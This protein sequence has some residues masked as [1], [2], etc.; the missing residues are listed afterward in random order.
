[1]TNSAD[2]REWSRVSDASV[3][4]LRKALRMWMQAVE[5][6]GDILNMGLHDP[7]PGRAWGILQFVVDLMQT[8][9]PSQNM[10]V[11]VTY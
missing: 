3:S 10:R 9:L 1:M 8:F 2:E 11:R 5:D 4:P 6:I 7:R